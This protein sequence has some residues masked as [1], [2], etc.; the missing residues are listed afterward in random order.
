[1]FILH[2]RSYSNSGAE[3]CVFDSRLLNYSFFLLYL[4]FILFLLS[5][6][7]IVGLKIE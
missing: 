6:F 1:M 5:F 7:L 2:L 3:D 4:F